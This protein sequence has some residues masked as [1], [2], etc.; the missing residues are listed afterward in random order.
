MRTGLGLKAQINHWSRFDR[1]NYF[2][3]DLPQGY[4]ISQYKDPIVGEGEIEVERDDGTTLHRA[5]R[6]AAPGAGRRQ[7]DP[8]PRSQRHLCRPQPRRHRADGDRL[9]PGHALVRR[10]GGLRE[11]AAHHPALSRHLRRRHGEG[12]PARRRERLGAQARATRSARAARSRTST[13]TASSSRRSSSRRAARSRSSKTAARSTRRPACSTR[14]KGETR[15]MRSK[16]E[17]HD[18]RYFPDPDL[19]PLVLDPAWVKEIEASLPELPDDKRQRLD[20]PVRPLAL[21]RRRAGD[22]GRRGP[23][24]SRPPPRAATPSWSPTGSTNDLLGRL[25]KDGLRHHARARSRR[26]TSPAWSS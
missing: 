22:R 3:P 13:P 12:Q 1:K 14:R 23:T 25:A 10:S 7:V 8:R 24:S 6:A 5:D 16:E 21:R 20:E 9:V 15:S 4:Q 19:L 11:E 26:R 18:Y 17:A 2:Y